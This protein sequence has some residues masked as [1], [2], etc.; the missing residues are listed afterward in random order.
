MSTC[1]SYILFA[2]LAFINRVSELPAKHACFLC[3]PSWCTIYHWVAIFVE[4]A[5]IRAWSCSCFHSR[6][7]FLPILLRIQRLHVF[8]GEPM[9]SLHSCFLVWSAATLFLDSVRH[10]G[11]D[12]FCR[13]SSEIVQT[14][15]RSYFSL[16]VYLSCPKN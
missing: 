11:F 7:P 3:I 4:E 2:L 1:R 6:Q 14:I 12:I 13:K 10:Y 16:F 5:R 15:P 8:G 9:I